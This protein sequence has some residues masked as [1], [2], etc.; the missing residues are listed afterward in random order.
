MEPAPRPPQAATVLA[1]FALLC[2]IWGSTWLVI[3]E[4]LHDLPPLTG[5]ALRFVVAAAV[6]AAM[7][8][9]LRR[10][11]GGRR[12]PVWLT[13]AIGSLN[14]AVSYAVVYETESVLPSGLT[15]VLW[16]VYPLM[17][18]AA[19]HWFLGELVG[20][21]QVLGFLLGFAGVV[22]LVMFGMGGSDLHAESAATAGAPWGPAL[23]LF[24]SPLVSA[25]GTTLVKRFGRGCSSVLLNRDAM[26]LGAVL[27]VAAAIA[28]ER[29]QDP[30]W[31]GRAIASVLYLAVVGTCLSFG[32]WFWLLRY[33]PANRMSLI[34]FVTPCIALLLGWAFGGET[35][36]QPALCGSAMVVGGV[37]LATRRR[38]A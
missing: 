31:T 32:L 24:L 17:M 35:I 15:S 5:A 38:K 21:V 36:T 27:L 13:V 8:P 34:S 26:A 18:A 4:G 2:L 30:Q 23:L 16:A 12:P 11:E 33:A 29:H 6:M 10:R 7:V 9:V 25:V 3:K 28:C 14:F 20:L 37:V 19:G 1:L 22:V